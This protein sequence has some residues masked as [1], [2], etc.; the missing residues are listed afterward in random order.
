MLVRLLTVAL[1]FVAVVTTGCEAKLRDVR[2][3]EVKAANDS[4]F[5]VDPKG[6]ERTVNVTAKSHGGAINVFVYLSKYE[7]QLE[8]DLATAPEDKMLARALD[9]TDAELSVVVPAN[10]A[11]SVVLS[12]VRT[13]KETVDLTITD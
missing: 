6:M 7:N 4:A 10:E 8:G 3:V 11:L 12:T 13:A 2:T 1:L 9:T 5:A